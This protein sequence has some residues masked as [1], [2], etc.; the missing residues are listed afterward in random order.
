MTF[1][2]YNDI[3]S[4]VTH[5]SFN[6]VQRHVTAFRPF[7]EAAQSWSYDSCL[8]YLCNAYTCNRHKVTHYVCPLIFITNL[9]Y[10]TFLHLR[11]S[12]ASS[13][14]NLRGWQSFSTTSLQVLLVF[15]LVWDPLRHTPSISSRNHHLLFT[16]HVHTIT[17]CFAVIPMLCGRLDQSKQCYNQ[18]PKRPS[19]PY[20]SEEVLQPVIASS[21]PSCHA[22]FHVILSASAGKPLSSNDSAGLLDHGLHVW[23]VTVINGR[24]YLHTHHSY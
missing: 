9:T 21:T 6:N 3:R 15:L 13:L 18:Q 20:R 22:I 16:T 7:S 8:W 2:H 19:P 11:Q 4:T 12:I 17:A 10:L 5:W 24:Q 14:I 23:W 1:Y